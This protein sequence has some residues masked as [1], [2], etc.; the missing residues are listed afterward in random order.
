MPE[1]FAGMNVGSNAFKS[2]MGAL[3]FK[4]NSAELGRNYYEIYRDSIDGLKIT[5]G[6]FHKMSY[7]VIEV[8]GFKYNVI[9]LTHAFGML[10]LT[11]NE[12]VDYSS[13]EDNTAHSLTFIIT[14]K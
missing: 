1:L 7:D 13:S 3:I 2:M 8:W 5:S 14:T 12:L 11:L 9:T 10:R 4:V 6:Y